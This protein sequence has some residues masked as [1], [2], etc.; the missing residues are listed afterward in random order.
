MIELK[1]Y[2]LLHQETPQAIKVIQ[3]RYMGDLFA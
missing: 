3:H 2:Y 1:F